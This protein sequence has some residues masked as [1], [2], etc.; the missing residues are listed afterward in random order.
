MKTNWFSVPLEND[1]VYIY[2]VRSPIDDRAEYHKFLAKMHCVSLDENK[3]IVVCLD[4]HDEFELEGEKNICELS[5]LT[6]SKLLNTKYRRFRSS[7]FYK[8][9]DGITVYREYLTTFTCYNSKVYAQ[10]LVTSDLEFNEN[11]WDLFNHDPDKIKKEIIGKKVY[12]IPNRSRNELIV[13]NVI[14]FNEKIVD[15]IYEYFYKKCNEDK[16][17]YDCSKLLPKSQ[18][19]TH[20]PILVAEPKKYGKISTYYF[21]PQLSKLIV[22]YEQINE[23]KRTKIKDLTTINNNDKIELAKEFVTKQIRYNIS[24]LDIEEISLDPPDLIARDLNGKEVTIGKGNSS[25]FKYKPLE[26]FDIDK[27]YIQIFI[28]RKFYKNKEK[29]KEIFND[30]AQKIYKTSGVQVE[31]GLPYYPDLDANHVSDIVRIV[32]NKYDEKVKTVVATIGKK[33]PENDYFLDLKKALYARKILHQNI[34][35]DTIEKGTNLKYIINNLI[36][37]ILS[38]LGVYYYGVK[39]NSKFDYIIGIDVGRFRNSSYGGAIT[40]FDNKG[41]IRKVVPIPLRASGEKTEIEDVFNILNNAMNMELEGKKLLILRDGRAPKEEVDKVQHIAESMNFD[42]SLI[43]VIKRHNTRFEEGKYNFFIKPRDNIA[44]FVA[45]GSNAAKP[46]K[47][48]KV[49]DSN[50][51][52]NISYDE[53]YTT[54]TLTRLDMARLFSEGK[55]LRLPAPIYYADKLVKLLDKGIQFNEDPL[56]E[57]FLFFI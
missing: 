17:S 33:L 24:P 12:A 14:D 39:T 19:D 34:L 4:K 10:I 28:D 25:I 2:E 5:D 47:L 30:I 29:I 13:T 44:Y 26:K 38:K 35:I 7:Q 32:S 57:G 52:S 27:V 56:K 46:V 31:I 36:L 22:R 51:S 50:R 43:N 20:Q 9:I 41:I 8:E 54:Y 49:M 18:I 37:Q 15:S 23:T 21:L 42:F 16:I 6:L 48:E 1:K 40:V 3:R 53:I 11:I 45:H 55:N